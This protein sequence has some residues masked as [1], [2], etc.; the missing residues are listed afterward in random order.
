MRLLK[1]PVHDGSIG[2][3]ATTLKNFSHDISAYAPQ[4][5]THSRSDSYRSQAHCV[6]IHLNY[7]LDDQH[8]RSPNPG[9]STDILVEPPSDTEL[10]SLQVKTLYSQDD[11]PS[12]QQ[13]QHDGNHR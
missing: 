1:V 9:C 8:D 7:W 6:A 11:I 2:S 12:L 10:H 13:R 5:A 3:L 4:A